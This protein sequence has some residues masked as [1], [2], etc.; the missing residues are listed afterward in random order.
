[1]SK[2]GKLGSANASVTDEKEITR[3]ISLATQFYTACWFHV[4]T[5]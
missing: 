4:A 5:S 2:E 3:A 1:M